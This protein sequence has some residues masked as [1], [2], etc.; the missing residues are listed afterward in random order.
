[1]KWF[2][3][4]SCAPVLLEAGHNYMM[5]Q[6]WT[7]EPPNQWW[8]P[9]STLTVKGTQAIR[10]RHK[11]GDFL[12]SSGACV[13][14]KVFQTEGVSGAP[15]LL[16]H[17]GASNH[18]STSKK[19]KL[20]NFKSKFKTQLKKQKDKLSVDII[21]SPIWISYYLRCEFSLLFLKEYFGF[22]LTQMLCLCP[23][24]KKIN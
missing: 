24:F 16:V 14:C 2:Y 22:R 5:F 4:N 8:D 6:G 3:C 15:G 17:P 9:S 20:Q 10:G 7:Q 1:M 11:L 13:F 21:Y 18:P 19:I 23:R 12:Y